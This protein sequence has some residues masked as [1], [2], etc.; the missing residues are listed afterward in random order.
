MKATWIRS[1]VLVAALPIYVFGQHEQH[2]P[3]QPQQPTKPTVQP[4]PPGHQ[5]PARTMQQNPVEELIQKAPSNIVQPLG[6]AQ[7]TPGEP[8]IRLQDL[9]KIALKNNPTLAQATTEIRGATGRTLQAG[10]WPNPRAGYTGEEIRGG[11]LGGGQH[12]FFVEQTIV[13]G[14]KLALSRNAARQEITLAEIEAEEQRLRVVNAVRLAYIETLASQELL[15]LHRAFV[16]IASQTLAT[17]QHLRNIGADDGSEVLQSEIA[18]QQAQLALKR[19]ENQHRRL[20]R[21]MA[22][23]VGDPSLRMTALEGRIDEG[24]PSLNAD[25]L[26]QALLSNSP[27]VR[28]ARANVTRNEALLTRARREAIPDLQVRAGLLQNREQLDSGRPIGLQ[29]QAEIGIQIPLF[30]RN[31]G[32]V[33]SVRAE[34]ER[35]QNEVR[36]IELILRERAAA[37][38]RA[39]EDA[40]DTVN[41]Y[42]K[43]VLPRARQLY[44]MQLKAWGQMAV[45]Y[46]V[47]LQA[48][49]TLF[50]VQQEYVGALREFQTSAV[51]M[52]GFLLT[53]GLE[54]PARPAETDLPVREV[55]VPTTRGGREQ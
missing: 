38:V 28:I 49:N 35:A 19:Q 23:V 45:S 37:T 52:R 47:V 41:T 50:E 33:Q 51:A 13:L 54:A 20:W 10:L 6:K 55:N 11:S 2:Q 42:Q 34:L 7:R 14:R 29:G 31:Q 5:A 48:Q 32:N 18:L 46:P 9:E 44:E 36:R 4:A 17:A 39:L 15:D 25:D 53:D 21:A 30:N 40:R 16:E 22:A 1:T 12:G 8:V 27:A 26:L 24:L 3:Q 43:D